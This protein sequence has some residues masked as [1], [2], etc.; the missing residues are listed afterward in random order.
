MGII[1]EQNR[2]NKLV[3]KALGVDISSRKINYHLFVLVPL[4]TLL[5]LVV[6]MEPNNRKS[7]SSKK[8]RAM[9]YGSSINKRNNL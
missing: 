1:I 2:T 5:N 9:T 7:E 4:I 6:T 8:T 3:I